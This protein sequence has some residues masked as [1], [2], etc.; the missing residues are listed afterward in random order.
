MAFPIRLADVMSS[1]VRTTPADATAAEAAA[2]CSQEDIGSLVVVEDGEPVGIVTS[3]DFVD[4]LGTDPDPGPR[5]VDEFMSSPVVTVPADTPV[6]EAVERMVEDGIARVVVVEDGELVG[7]VSTDDVVHHVPQVFHRTQFEVPPVESHQYRIHQETA[8]EAPDWEF[9]CTCRSEESV[10]VGDRVTFSKTISEQDVRSFATASGDTN[11][12][13]LD[14]DYAEGTRFER[15]IVHG[16]LVGGLISAALAR[17]PGLTIYVSQDITFLSPVDIGERVTAVCSV[18]ESL[19][20]K[21]YALTT[22]VH[23]ADGEQVIEGEAV[24]L[25]DAPPATASIEVEAIP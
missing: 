16:T 22:D 13:H 8:Y 21:K 18:T 15:R 23:G 12:L 24:V 19:G 6:G 4:L 9:E 2:T 11:R 5:T 14:D 3:S 17:L 7:L 10:S 20:R 25:I 1:P